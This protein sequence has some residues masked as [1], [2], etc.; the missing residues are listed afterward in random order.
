MRAS[1]SRS[2][3]DRTLKNQKGSMSVQ[4]DTLFKPGQAGAIP[5]ANRVFMA[6]MTRNRAGVPG[7]LAVDYYRQR[8][9]AGLIVTEATQVSPQ[10]QGYPLTPGIHNQEQ[11]AA[12]RRITDAVHGAG[13]RIALQ[14]WHVGR[15]SHPS[16][17]PEG[18]LPVAP[19]AIAPEGQSITYEGMQPF[20]TPRALETDE[21]PGIVEQ[22]RHGAELAKQAGFDG[23]EVHGANGYLIDQFLRD[24]S[25]R[26][27]DRYGGSIENRLRLLLEV[28][29]AV[30]G[31]WG[32]D[33]VGVRLSP[34][35]PFNSTTDSDPA[36][37]FGR[38]VAALNGLGL[39]YLH[40]VEPGPG[41][42]GQDI[43]T[44]IRASWTG[45]YV[46]N[47]G[48]TPDTAAL[49]LASGHADAVAFGKPYIS[50]PDLTDRVRGNAPLTSP[51]VATFYIG[52]AKGYVDY[53]ALSR[54]A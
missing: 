36:S 20:V 27:T 6:P 35:N 39:A 43:L 54:A 38:A 5:V 29:E 42:E 23:V 13:G 46:A 16:L 49:A 28:T 21:V 2:V 53:P 9:G 50:N 15:I 3:L 19:S 41:A 22:F 40:L 11:V 25:N 51:D 26:R 14:L 18:G 44:R 34:L 12:W 45:F 32:P 8:A 52:G 24:G 33:R 48:Y 37:H 17:Q 1:F 4:T 10:G 47:G 31:V 7:E 30:T